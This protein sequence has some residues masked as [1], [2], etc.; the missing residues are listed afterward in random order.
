MPAAVLFRP[1]E[2][3]ERADEVGRSL[4]VGGPQKS[5]LECAKS[6]PQL[7]LSDVNSVRRRDRTLKEAI[8]EGNSEGV[9][10]NEWESSSS[11]EDKK[12]SIARKRTSPLSRTGRRQLNLTSCQLAVHRGRQPC[13]L[14]G[15]LPSFSLET[16]FFDQRCTQ[17]YIFRGKEV[18]VAVYRRCAA[19][20]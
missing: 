6:K 9:E 3:W 20:L 17:R 16:R 11:E 18:A 15:D 1:P 2:N 7:L 14:E 4:A 13:Q 8:R 12:W 5:G 10:G 19:V